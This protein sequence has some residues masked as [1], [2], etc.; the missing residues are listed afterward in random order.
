M[1]VFGFLRHRHDMR[2]QAVRCVG[3]GAPAQARILYVATMLAN[4]HLLFRG[5]LANART[6]VGATAGYV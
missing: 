2:T 1:I 6:R 3:F 5:E 4:G